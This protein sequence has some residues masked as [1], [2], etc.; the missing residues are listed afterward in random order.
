MARDQRADKQRGEE[1]EED[2][3]EQWPLKLARAHFLPQALSSPPRSPLCQKTDSPCIQSPSP[4]L[5]PH[6]TF[7]VVP[8]SFRKPS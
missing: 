5:G 3:E 8:G 1:E 6:Q 7:P 2:R 4:H